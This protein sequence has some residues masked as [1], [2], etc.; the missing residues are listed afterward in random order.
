MD[1]RQPYRE[2]RRFFWRLGLAGAFIL[3]L[4]LVLLGRLAHIQLL[5]HDRFDTL[6][7]RN[8][9]ALLPLSPARGLLLDR[10]G[11]VLA[12][13]RVGYVLE[14]IPNAVEDM[15]DTITRLQEIVP[16]GADDLRAF[17]Q[18]LAR[19][20]PYQPV[21]LRRNL[22]AEEVAALAVRR[23]QFP[24]VEVQAK[25]KRYYPYGPLFAHVLGYVGHLSPGDVATDTASHYAGLDYIGKTGI[26]AEYEDLLRGEPGDEQVEVNVQGR[27]LRTLRV[28]PPENGRTL[29][30]SLDIALQEAA[31]SAMAGKNGAVVALDPHTGEILAAYSSPGFDPNAFVDGIGQSRWAT[32]RDDPQAP[33]ANRFLRGEYPPGSTIKPFIAAA[34]LEAGAISPAERLPGGGWYQIPG[35]KHRYYDWKPGGH[36]AENVVEAIRD[37]NDI[38]FYQVAMRLG[39]GRLSTGVAPFG[40]GTR[41]GIDLPGERPGVLP[42]PEWLWRR[43]RQRWYLGQTVIAGIGQGYWLTTPLQLARATAAMANGGVLP[44]PHL[45]LYTVADGRRTALADPRATPVGLDAATLDVIRE[46]MR[47]VVTSGTARTLATDPIPIA[48]KTGT[49]Q[50]RGAKRDA[51]GRILDP[52]PEAYRDH[53]LFIAY[54]PVD[55]PRIAVAVVVEHGGHGGSAAGPV[56]RAVIDTYLGGQPA[57][58]NGQESS[59]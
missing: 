29:V 36:G 32:L 25:L 28:T 11:R 21:V 19:G 47:A 31:A 18:G 53:A 5:Q 37:S 8:C 6:S 55:N 56:A 46:G 58:V 59:L 39:I 7:A 34:A 48:A 45:A 41:T 35:S 24:G 54:A 38:Y 2:Q 13:N 15:D 17:Q 1:I 43:Y 30:L 57:V 3:I 44:T 26:E 22:T 14:I 52:D 9:I 20:H 10:N 27:P 51:G 16:I 23:H 33:M 4:A 49:A 40:F 50:V 42:T 12:E